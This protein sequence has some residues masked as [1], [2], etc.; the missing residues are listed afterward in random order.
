MLVQLCCHLYEV[1]LV[2]EAYVKRH[3]FALQLHSAILGTPWKNVGVEGVKKDIYTKI[4]HFEHDIMMPN[5][6]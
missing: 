3:E 1:V 4:Y 2:Q 5:C 6:I